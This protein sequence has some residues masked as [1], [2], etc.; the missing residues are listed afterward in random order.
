MKWTGIAAALVLA[1]APVAAQQPAG[2]KA[3]ASMK[4]I[5]LQGCVMAG[6]EKDMVLMTHVREQAGAR[7]PLPADAHGR[8]VLFWLDNDTQLKPHVGH[9]VEVMGMTTGE[10]E[11]S[12][13]EVKAGK[14]KDGGTVVEFEGPGRDVTASAAVVGDAVGTSGR[15]PEANDIKTFLFKVKVDSVRAIEGNCQA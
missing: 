9:M 13:I 8:K 11:K 12:E 3:D 14:H 5:T 6:T 10:I 2:Q 1:A 4:P 7:S 15:A